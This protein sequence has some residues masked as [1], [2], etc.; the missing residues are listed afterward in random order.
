VKYKIGDKV[1]LREEVGV[2]TDGP[3]RPDIHGCVLYEV[4]IVEAGPWKVAVYPIVY[5]HDLRPAPVK[6]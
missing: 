1:M 5:E 6:P 4:R 2:I 3:G